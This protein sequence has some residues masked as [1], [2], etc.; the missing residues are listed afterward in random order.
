MTQQTLAEALHVTDKAVSKWERGLSLPDICL[1]SNLANVLNVSTS[2]LLLECSDEETPSHLVQIYEA[3]ADIRAP[4]HIILG[5]VELLRRYREN[6]GLF[7]RYLESIRISGEYLLAVVEKVKYPGQL[8]HLLSQPGQPSRTPAVTYDFT[9]KRILIVEDMEVNREIAAEILRGTGASFDFAEDGQICLDM[10][11][12]SPPEY[13]DLILMDISMPRMDGL[14]ATRKLRQRGCSLPIIAMTANVSE[15]DR[16]AA[17][18]AGMNA[19]AEKP[20]FIDKLFAV[21]SEY[22]QEKQPGSVIFGRAD[23]A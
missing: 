2:D 14:E 17:M 23:H 16:N 20:I 21:L 10:V 19:F 18:E 6:D 5:C 3:G 22:L 12:S 7:E 11:S 4:L 1:F 13:Y 8:D 15:Q 9:G